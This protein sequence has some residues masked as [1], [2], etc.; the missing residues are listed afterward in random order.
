MGLAD[1]VGQLA[2]QLQPG[3]LQQVGIVEALSFH[4]AE[5]QRQYGVEVTF[6]ATGD[7]ASIAPTKPRDACFAA[8]RR[9]SATSP[10]TP[11]RAARR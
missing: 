1:T 4:C 7:L 8:H 2:H 9:R 3:G 5:F 11:A 6:D 10:G